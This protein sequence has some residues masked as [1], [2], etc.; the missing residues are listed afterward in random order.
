MNRMKT[1]RCRIVRLN[2]GWPQYATYI[3][4]IDLIPKGWSL[5]MRRVVRSKAA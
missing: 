5:M 1:F 4:P 3:G 2:D